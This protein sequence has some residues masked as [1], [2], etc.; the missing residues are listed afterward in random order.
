MLAL[1]S[2]IRTPAFVV[3][4]AP[5]APIVAFLY[6][7]REFE[8]PVK[9][10]PNLALVPSIKEVA[11]GSNWILCVVPASVYISNLGA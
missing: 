8:G 11:P 7:C 9:P 1:L 4:I 5:I 2:C 6:T 10:I 3:V